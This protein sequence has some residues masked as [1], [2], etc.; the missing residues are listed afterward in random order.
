MGSI[1]DNRDCVGGVVGSVGDSSDGIDVNPVGPVGPST[2]N[3]NVNDNI[4]CRI[5][6]GHCSGS[7]VRDVEQVSVRVD[8]HSN[9][10]GSNLDGFD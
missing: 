4:V 1:T 3:R 7:E 6:Y 10:E 2:A 9:R 8:R 5:D